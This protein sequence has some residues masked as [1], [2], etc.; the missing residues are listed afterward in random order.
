MLTRRNRYI[1]DTWLCLVNYLSFLG[2]NFWTLL[3]NG[4]INLSITMTFVSTVSALGM[5]PLWIFLLGS[6]LSDDDLIIPYGQLMMTLVSL[7]LPISLGM[8]IR[9][10]FTK[11]A[12]IMK[13]IIVPFT[14]LTVLF[15]FTVKWEFYLKATLL[16]KLS[17]F[18]PASTSTYSFSC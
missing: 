10:R 1:F 3:L 8:W 2:S 13:A 4:D 14:L 11:G 6:W 12:K 15:I 7:V 9:F 16:L 17:Y 5:M 18:R